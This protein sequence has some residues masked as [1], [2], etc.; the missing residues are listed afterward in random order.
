M[1]SRILLVEDD[2]NFRAF[3]QTVL[4]D[5][6]YEVVSVEDG[7][8]GLKQ[9]HSSR[10]DVVVSDLKMPG[11]SGFDLFKEAIHEP[12]PP[13]FIFLTA[14]GT[15]E[16][17]VSAIKNGAFDFLTK[18]LKNPDALLEV[19]RRALQSQ[20]LQ[21][22]CLSQSETETSGLPPADLIFAGHA[23]ESVHTLVHNVAVTTANV[24]IHGESG[25]GKELIARAIHLLSPRCKNSFVAL[26]CA[27]IPENL[28]ESELFGHEKG[29]FT[30]AVQARKGKFEQAEGGTIFLD[31]I[32]EM[33]LPLQS[34]LLRV[35]Q[36]RVFE[37]V[38]GSRELKSNVRVIAATNRDLSLEVSKKRFRE[39]L[40]YRLNVFPIS[41]PPLRDRRDCIPLLA[42]YFLQRF[43]RQNDKNI[44][45]IEPEAL[46]SMDSYSW[47]GNIR[48]L[49]NIM[50][51]AVI[52][53]QDT[54]IRCTNILV[55][56]PHQIEQPLQADL[57]EKLEGREL[58]RSVERDMLFKALDQNGGNRRLAAEA[59]GISR[60]SLQYKLK[61]FGLL[62]G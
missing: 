54:I 4:E 45:G 22:E 62:N 23:M 41:L 27:A 37:R 49:Q 46:S 61:E 24:L 47:P 7:V 44:L 16:E 42:H 2:T 17:A 25:T 51:R 32:G 28:L 53:S 40:Y 38:G 39:D 55:R 18:P 35:L 15:V 60:R 36:E 13:L 31:E 6:G 12:K 58:L 8:T 1:K 29:A 26:N 14:F 50:E 52:L 21:R 57:P 33:P 30:G 3:M 5:E 59:L 19:V 48:E 34:K 43:S 56:T 10:F 9:I 20:P 11:I